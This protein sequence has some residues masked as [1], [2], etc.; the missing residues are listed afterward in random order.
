M[1]AKDALKISETDNVAVALKALSGG[2]EVT[3]GSRTVVIREPIL[4]YH[5]FAL[6]DIASG[7]RVFKYGEVIGE[8]T[9]DI[10]AGSHVHVHNVRTLRG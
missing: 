5:K 7:D 2:A 6:E 8:A 9:A 1:N 3:V 10:P 4:A